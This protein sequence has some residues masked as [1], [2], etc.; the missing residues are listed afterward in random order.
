MQDSGASF[1]KF[2]STDFQ[3]NH[4]RPIAMK[5]LKTLSLDKLN[6]LSDVT[7]A[8]DKGNL[9]S[10]LCITDPIAG[11]V[12]VFQKGK[13]RWSAGLKWPFKTH[14]YAP[15]GQDY[16]IYHGVARSHLGGSHAPSLGSAYRCPSHR[17]HNKSKLYGKSRRETIWCS[18]LPFAYDDTCLFSIS[19]L[20]A[21]Y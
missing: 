15:D 1:S 20:C 11:N 12:Y 14:R 18:I 21:Y 6:L 8:V 9:L 2:N 17:R 10:T 7:M 13:T 5:C 4:Q 16:Q 3:H 19:D